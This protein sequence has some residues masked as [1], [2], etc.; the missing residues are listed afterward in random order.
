MSDDASGNWRTG[1]AFMFAMIAI[2][3]G[4]RLVD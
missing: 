4:T 2:L 3:I 1:A